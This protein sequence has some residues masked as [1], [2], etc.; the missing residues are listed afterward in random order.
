MDWQSRIMI[1]PKV[2]VGKPV[3]KGTRISVEFILGLM[4]QGWDPA[5]ILEQYPFLQAEDLKA[6]FRY[7][8]LLVREA[9]VTNA[10]MG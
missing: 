9:R 8:E 2:L 3:V 7:A 6:C 5:R 1:D 4:A 10:E